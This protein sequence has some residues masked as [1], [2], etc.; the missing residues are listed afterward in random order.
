MH[1]LIWYPRSRVPPN[2]YACH[3]TLVL[4]APQPAANFTGRGRPVPASQRCLAI[5]NVA[6][7]PISICGFPF[8]GRGSE[9]E[10]RCRWRMCGHPPRRPS[11]TD[12]ALAFH[13]M[14]RSPAY[15]V[16]SLLTIRNE[17]CEPHRRRIV[18]FSSSV[19]GDNIGPFHV[20]TTLNHGCALLHGPLPCYCRVSRPS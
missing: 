3:V 10:G 11:F 14:L 5:S 18:A 6:S 20:V 2:R 15:N 7:R 13:L 12:T 4:A 17:R 16:H 8:G 1:I 19:Q 9:A